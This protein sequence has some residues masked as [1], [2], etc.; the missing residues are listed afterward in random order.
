MANNFSLFD[1]LGMKPQGQ[2]RVVDGDSLFVHLGMDAPK[3]NTVIR[4]V[5]KDAQPGPNGLMW[6]K[7]GGYDSKTGELVVGGQPFDKSS[8]GFMGGARAFFD[9]VTNGV[10]LVGPAIKGGIQRA[11]AIIAAGG[12]PADY[13]AV[14][15]T[16]QR[17][18]GDAE[19][20]HPYSSL[21]GNVGGAVSGYLVAGAPAFGAKV[22]GMA[23]PSMASRMGYGTV[24]NALVGGADAAIR[25]QDP[26]VGAAFGA[27]GGFVGPGIGGLLGGAANKITG[28]VKSFIPTG[29][30]GVSR[31]AANVLTD[32]IHADDPAAVR[33]ALAQ[34]GEFGMLADAGPSLTSIAGGLASKPGEAQGIVR[35]ALEQRQAGATG[36]LASDINSAIG[37]APVPSAV[38][39]GIS[40]NME[41][42]GPEYQLAMTT[43]RAVNTEPLAQALDASVANLRGPAAQ[44]VEK[45][46]G[47]LN[48]RGTNQLDPNPQALLATRHAIDGMMDGEANTQVIRHLT[49]ARQQV[50]AELARAVPGIKAIDAKYAELGR[51]GEGLAQ[52]G[53]LLDSGKT[54][55]HPQDLATSFPQSALPQ[56]AQIGPSA[57]PMRM[58]QGARAEIDRLVGTKSNDLVALKSMLQGEG[59]WNT[60]KLGTV[61]GEEPTNRLLGSV[62]REAKFA[63]TAN[64]VTRNSETARR[65]EAN[66]LLNAAEPGS[67][68]LSNSSAFGLGAQAVK[69]LAVDPL[70]SMI[71][72]TSS[73]PMRAEMARVLTMQGQSRDQIVNRLLAMHKQQGQVS[74]IGGAISNAANA[75]GNLLTLGASQAMRPN[76]Q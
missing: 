42:L 10:P 24:S 30:S 43:A 56:G 15:Q 8:Q 67:T 36:R 5:P 50:D 53:S 74:A 3:D 61:F 37:P 26:L 4:D 28:Y 18:S 49:M 12:N 75:G 22:L 17:Q 1:D 46:R 19:A 23:G 29:V 41:A 27:A 54:A 13:P 45:V 32:M 60:A 14:L 21:A 34:A 7:D 47:F 38:Q 65:A 40:A 66:A 69:K 63:D 68:N 6:N 71:L 39:Q 62:G 16:I 48:I 51:Q 58:Q 35:S 64:T 72:R 59:G 2:S 76:S 70:I 73:E 9:G 44:A 52:G 33:A 55:I 31:P 11:A 20:S 25:G 57:V